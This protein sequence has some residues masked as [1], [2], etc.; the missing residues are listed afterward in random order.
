MSLRGSRFFFFVSG[1][2]VFEMM[3]FRVRTGLKLRETVGGRSETEGRHGTL[4]FGVDGQ[5]MI[6]SCIPRYSLST[7]FY[8]E[9]IGRNTTE[10]KGI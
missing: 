1:R 4:G 9:G 2:H 10:L 7:G 8:L 6:W 3:P 5:V